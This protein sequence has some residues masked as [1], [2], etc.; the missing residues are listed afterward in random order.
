[1]SCLIH[2]IPAHVGDV[3]VHLPFT[4]VSV[5]SPLA[6]PNPLLHVYVALEPSKVPPGVATVA[7]LT[8]GGDSQ[9]AVGRSYSQNV[10]HYHAHSTTTTHMEIGSFLC[11]GEVVYPFHYA[12]SM[13]MYLYV[14]VS[15]IV[16]I[17]LGY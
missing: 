17:T 4:H 1:M 15:A 6:R 16:G 3:P 13:C 5:A 8:T 11:S 14:N 9:S 12:R 7:S 10:F 2:H